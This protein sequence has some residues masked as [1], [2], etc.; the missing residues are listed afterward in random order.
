VLLIG[1]KTKKATMLLLSLDRSGILC[2]FS[3]KNTKIQRIARTILTN[4]PFVSAPK[5][6]KRRLIVSKSR[7]F[8]RFE[9]G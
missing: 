8:V 7:D 5:N 2:L 6:L 1:N 4:K 3:L 9:N